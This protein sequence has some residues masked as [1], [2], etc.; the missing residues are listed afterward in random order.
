MLKARRSASTAPPRSIRIARL[1]AR[2]LVIAAVAALALSATAA[3]NSRA[4]P[5][6]AASCANGTL[7]QTNKGPICGLTGPNYDQW[8]GVRS[9]RGC[10]G[11]PVAVAFTQATRRLDR[12]AAGG[13][14]RQRMSAGWWRQPVDQRGLPVLERH[15]PDQPR[16]EPAA[17][18]HVH[19]RR[20]LPNGETSLYPFERAIS[21][22][23]EYNSLR[24]RRPRCSRGTVRMDRRS[25][26]TGSPSTR[27]H[28]TGP[29]SRRDELDQNAQGRI[30][31][32]PW[33]ARTR[34]HRIPNLRLDACA[35]RR[36]SSPTRTR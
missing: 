25:V 3:A 19:R 4:K 15:G 34:I 6:Q 22:S 21:I 18:A 9:L 28:A 7:I 16:T 30:C 13:D 36:S 24:V 11:R 27:R 12:P 14:A 17:R 32:L 29:R 31:C 26:A 2:A 1:P 8:L 33:S 5:A 10:A 35:A 20:R 23:G